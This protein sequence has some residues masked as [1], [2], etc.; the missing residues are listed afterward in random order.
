MK[1]LLEYNSPKYLRRMIR[2]INAEKQT[3]NAVYA[4]WHPFN[5]TVASVTYGKNFNK[6]LVTDYRGAMTAHGHDDFQDSN[7]QQI[8]ASRTP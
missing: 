2:A 4:R 6:I 1:A 8:C 7:G 5:I 3:G